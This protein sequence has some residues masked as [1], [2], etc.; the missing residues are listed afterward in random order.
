MRTNMAEVQTHRDEW[1]RPLGGLAGLARV[2]LERTHLEAAV[3]E[4]RFLAT[5]SELPESDAVSIWEGLGQATFPVFEKHVQN[6]VNLIVSPRGASQS[7]GVQHGWVLANADRSTWVTLLPSTVVVQTSSYD[8]Y[9][10]S[11][12]DPLRRVLSLFTQTTGASVVQRLGLRFINK[13][14]DPAA[15]S[16]Q[17]WRD[18]IR[19]DFAGPMAG[20]LCE[21]VASQHQQVQF[22][23]DPTAAARIQSGVFLEPGAP[24]RYSFLVDLDVFREH[25]FSYKD[26]QCANLVRQL[27]RTALALFAH[28]LSDSYLADLGSVSLDEEEAR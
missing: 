27:N 21:L 16:P 1:D 13:L 4:V 26:D 20:D 7:T 19:D 25:S 28:V 3:A 11:L 8:R 2:R 12:G 6:I 18:H 14:A 17:F 5:R 24:Q 22:Q 15:T 23:L 9:S 10:T